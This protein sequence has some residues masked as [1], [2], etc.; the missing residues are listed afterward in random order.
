M[1]GKGKQVECLNC[2]ARGPCGMKN[3]DEA[4]KV[5]ENGDVGYKRYDL[6]LIKA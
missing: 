4:I 5:W 2:G 1:D 6:R 3:D